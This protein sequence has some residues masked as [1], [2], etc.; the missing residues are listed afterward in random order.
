M[1]PGESS[2][3][4]ESAKP[5]KPADPV[6]EPLV[7]SSESA[8]DPVP[9]PLATSSESAAGPAPEPLVTPSESAAVPGVTS[10]GQ[11]VPFDTSAFDNLHNDQSS[12]EP[13]N[14]NAENEFH[15]RPTGALAPILQPVPVA[16]TEEDLKDLNDEDKADRQKEFEAE[17]RKIRNRQRRDWQPFY[18][19]HRH[20]FPFQCGYSCYSSGY[21]LLFHCLKVGI[22]SAKPVPRDYL[23]RLQ[24][25]D[26]PASHLRISHRIQGGLVV[27]PSRQFHR[28]GMTSSHSDPCEE[29]KRFETFLTTHATDCTSNTLL[30][31]L[32]ETKD[33]RSIT[34][35]PNYY[36][37]CWVVHLV[38]DIFANK[39]CKIHPTETTPGERA[40]VVIIAPYEGQQKLYHDLFAK[41]SDAEFVH[42]H[43]MT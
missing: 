2:K 3:A 11:K 12:N 6:P 13:T 36:N 24:G 39:I 34:T 9:E 30:M 1:D 21:W 5:A 14:E 33:D 10:S 31:F 22:S 17:L 43:V 37:A 40:R 20:S 42:A 35:Y 32:K 41:L 15:L 7:T 27:F 19:P 25:A 26:P 8:A 23:K 4:G 29:A 16:P 28:D 18:P 38:I